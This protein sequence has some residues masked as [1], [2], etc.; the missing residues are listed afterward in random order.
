M[1]RGFVGSPRTRALGISA[2]AIVVCAALINSESQ[3]APGPELLRVEVVETLPHDVDSFTQGLEISDGMLYEGTGL[4]GESFVSAT[5]LATG[6]ERAR[7]ELPAS[8]FGEGITLTDD[9]L[10]QLTWTDGI[11]YER[12]PETLRERRTVEYEGEGWGLCYQPGRERLVMSD[13]SGTLA[14]RDPD[15]FEQTGSVEVRS[16]GEVVDHLNELE[17]VDGKVYANIWQTDTIVRIDPETGAVTGEI[18]ASGLLT[19]SEAQAAD[20]LNGIARAPED[21]TFFVTGK[22][23]PHLFRV[24]FVPAS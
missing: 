20:V 3:A 9:S 4:T 6:E 12:D 1:R 8:V 15:T 7:A 14:F 16:A 23:W 24:R 18:D 17:C 11:A 22:L 21:G 5:E 10:W 19:E 13:G 2:L